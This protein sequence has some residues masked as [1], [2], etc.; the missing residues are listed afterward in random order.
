VN[1]KVVR[2]YVGG[3]LLGQ[4]AARM[5]AEERRRREEEAA[6]WKEEQERMEALTAPVEE[7]CE[8][9]ELLARATLLASGYHRHNRGEWRTSVNKEI[10]KASRPVGCPSPP[11]LTA[12]SEEEVEERG[13]HRAVEQSHGE[14]TKGQQE[15]R[16]RDT[17]DS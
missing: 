4:L 7:L 6:A 5:D 12:M 17:P 13:D 9:A 2:E 15:G 14:G 8:G 3:G 10:A 11:G 1:G 16:P